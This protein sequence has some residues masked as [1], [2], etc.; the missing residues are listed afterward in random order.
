MRLRL[1]LVEHDL[2]T[3]ALVMGVLTAGIPLSAQLAEADQ[4]VASGADLLDVGR[5]GAPDAAAEE[6]ELDRVATV[7]AALRSRLDVPLAVETWRPRVLV[8]ACA[9][10]AAVGRD[11]T[12]FADEGYL[13]AA[14]QAGA[15][16][17]ATHARLR[18]PGP[19]PGPGAPELVEEVRSFLRDRVRRAEAAGLPAERVIVDAGLD[20]GKTPAQSLTL[21]RESAALADL[22]P[23]LLLGAS[24][25]Y[26]GVLLGLEVD[27]RRVA[28][29]AATALAVAR[30]CRIVRTTDVRGARRVADVLD[31]VLGARLAQ[32]ER[33]VAGSDA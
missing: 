32:V 1:G 7:V 3:R 5:A 28:G 25:R 11:A 26:L 8:A 33:A 13:P 9:A 18:R 19:G 23:P 4:M 12:G 29:H 6:E 30:G 24:S 20:L 31:A 17:V 27:E 15:T 14:A 2:T 22:G 10:G 16:V 21:L